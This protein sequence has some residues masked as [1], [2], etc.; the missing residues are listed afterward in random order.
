MS[1]AGS[2][3]MDENRDQAMAH[4]KSTTPR[5]G[6]SKAFLAAAGVSAVILSGCA[7]PHDQLTTGGIP[8]DYRARHPIIVTE[9]EQ[10]VDIPVASTDRRLTSA[11]RD[12]IRG[13]AANYMARASGPV[14]V[15]SPQGSPNSAAAYQLRNQVRAELASRGIASSKI[16]NTS[17]AAVGPGDAAPIRLSFT[18]TTAITTQCGQWPKD[19][20]N[21]F[22]NQNYYNFGCASQNN[23]AA[24]IANPEDLVAPR[25]MTPIDAQRRNNAIQEYRTTTSTIEGVGGTDSSF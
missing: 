10:T 8:D 15:L 16:V 23:L 13:F 24:Q 7:G 9:A 20:S 1:G 18:G 6:I 14:Y 19:I 5:R 17:Y 2:A 3:A 25:G 12:L 22:T 4:M 11:Q 21:D